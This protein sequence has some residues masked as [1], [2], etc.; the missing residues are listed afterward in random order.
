MSSTI[1][2]TQVEQLLRQGYQQAATEILEKHLLAIPHDTAAIRML[3]R[4]RMIQGRAS[5]AIALIKQSLM[6]QAS[7]TSAEFKQSETYDS[8]IE[9]VDI[10]FIQAI[11]TNIKSNRVHFSNLSNEYYT[12]LAY[13]YPIEP[14]ETPTQWEQQVIYIQTHNT[15]IDDNDD[16]YT[17]FTDSDH[18]NSIDTEIFEPISDNSTD[19]E[20]FEKVTDDDGSYVF[21]TE[22]DHDDHIEFI[23][24]VDI[25]ISEKTS[26]WEKYAL[27]A[28]EPEEM[29][30]CEEF[31]NEIQ[32]NG[33]LTRAERAMQVAIEVGLK[34]DWDKTEIELLALVFE[35]HWWSSARRSM[36]RELAAGLK[37]EELSLAIALRE[38]WDNHPEFASCCTTDY[39][40]HTY[41][42]LTWPLALALVRTWPSYPEPIEVEKFLETLFAEWYNHPSIYRSFKS[43]RDYL[44]HCLH[45]DY[46]THNY[47]PE[48]SFVGP[49]C[50]EEWRLDS[51]TMG[52]PVQQI[53]HLEQM[54][55][56]PQARVDYSYKI[57]SNTSNEGMKNQDCNPTKISSKKFKKPYGKIGRQSKN[58]SL[59]KS[60]KDYSL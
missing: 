31:I 16:S 10:D 17:S 39:I 24:S 22:Y 33:T 29:P 12:D 7:S 27:D 36:E 11:A 26:D 37:P 52:P 60:S 18:D 6:L 4:V 34:Y 32:A 5:E 42:I 41:K 53:K 48:W 59:R 47:W 54:N 40:V 3:A 9:Q 15:T 25:E 13:E 51:L 58:N 21:P 50:P 45:N 14:E 2:V 19:S 23:N 49:E 46:N 30:T 55:L 20:I 8:D 43:F 35:R 28:D 57:I 1:I 38:I 44:Y 56:L